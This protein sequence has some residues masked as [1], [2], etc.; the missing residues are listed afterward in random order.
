M[1]KGNQPNDLNNK[2]DILRFNLIQGLFFLYTCAYIVLHHYWV[3][4]IIFGG[5]INPVLYAIL[6]LIGILFGIVVLIYN[7]KKETHKAMKTA[8]YICEAYCLFKLISLVLTLLIWSFAI[9]IVGKETSVQYL[10]AHWTDDGNLTVLVDK[11]RKY[12]LNLRYAK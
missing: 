10:L 1:L 12:L 3:R 8:C 4:N 5:R 11:Y 9:I 6:A 2:D 7:M